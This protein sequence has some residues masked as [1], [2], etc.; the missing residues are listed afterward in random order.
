[1]AFTLE[2]YLPDHL[3]GML[4]LYN[5]Q[6]A[7]E[8]HIALLSPALFGELVE[9]KPWFDATG[10]LV[11]LDRGAVVG[12]VHACVAP[13]T[14]P[15]HD[16]VQ[17]TGRIAMLICPP[18]H[19]EVG[20][21]L[22]A[23][24]TR[25]LADRGQHEA[26]ALH[27]Q[28]G[29]PLYRGLWMGGEPICPTTL[30]HLHLAFEVNGYHA[31]LESVF[32]TARLD[33]APRVP[34]PRVA[35][36]FEAGEATMAH[37]GMRHSWTGFRPCSVRA[38]VHG[39]EA[40]FLGWAMLPHVAARLGAPCASI[41]SLG[42]PEAHR[43]QGIAAALVGRALAQAWAEGA[44]FVSLGTQLWNSAAHATYARFGMAPE[45]LIIGRMRNPTVPEAR[46]V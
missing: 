20:Q 37:D 12:W 13:G 26:M 19:L 38:R 4:Q 45:R 6:T 35:V 30:P 8:P 17:R 43:R 27:A 42:V 22:V 40:G 11:A 32:M 23:E 25:W 34:Q 31:A 29:Y 2:T 7:G 36:E 14:E 16:G 18:Q 21:A 9:A 41:W 15:W 1:M 5:A 3:E 44:R 28:G 10:L 33:S 46:V 24:A 39:Q